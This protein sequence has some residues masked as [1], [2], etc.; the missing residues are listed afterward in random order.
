[1]SG[2]AG[3]RMG[4]E[5]RWEFWRWRLDIWRRKLFQP[6]ER[7]VK[8]R[9]GL[10]FSFPCYSARSSTEE[11]GGYWPGLHASRSQTLL[12]LQQWSKTRLRDL[13]L[14]DLAIFKR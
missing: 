2:W 11:E 4:Y 6:G 7:R 9:Q 12:T 10:C 8:R 3:S 13:F 14:R 5:E 1:V